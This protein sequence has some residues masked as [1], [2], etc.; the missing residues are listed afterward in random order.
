MASTIRIAAL[1][2][3]VFAA[4]PAAAQSNPFARFPRFAELANGRWNGVDLERRTRCTNPQNEGTRGT[5]A[6][7]DVAAEANGVFILAFDMARLNDASLLELH[8]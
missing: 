4:M 5:Y 6:Q 2:C 7:F 3:L 8:A 1:A